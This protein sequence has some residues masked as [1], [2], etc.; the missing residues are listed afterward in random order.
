M[1]DFSNKT[2]EG[3]K[4]AQ[5]KRRKIRSIPFSFSFDNVVKNYEK[6]YNYLA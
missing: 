1:G 6:C 3:G 4:Q 5:G 2:P